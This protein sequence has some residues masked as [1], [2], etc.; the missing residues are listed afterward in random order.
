MVTTQVEDE[1]QAPQAPVSTPAGCRAPE[2]GAQHPGGSLREVRFRTCPHR[3]G[4][5]TQAAGAQGL[6]AAGELGAGPREPYRGPQVGAA[7][8]STAT[9]PLPTP[10]S[11]RLDH[12]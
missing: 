10:G 4:K 9:M 11:P 1:V 6:T 7:F 2:G 5:G 12:A 8:R 3:A